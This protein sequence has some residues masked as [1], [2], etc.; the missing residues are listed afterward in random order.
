MV[1]VNHGRDVAAYRSGIFGAELKKSFQ[2][3]F[4][5][6][7]V[8]VDRYHRG[9]RIG[10]KGIEVFVV[11]ACMP[12]TLNLAP[13]TGDRYLPTDTSRA[14]LS[15]CIRS[16]IANPEYCSEFTPTLADAYQ[17]SCIEWAPELMPLR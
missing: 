4:P 1:G 7:A 8:I 15:R 3:V 13:I 12:N 16:F 6:V 14:G 5:I 2:G 11:A 9:L 10:L 17:F